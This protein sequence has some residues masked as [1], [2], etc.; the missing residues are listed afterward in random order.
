[1]V[2]AS[3]TFIVRYPELKEFVDNLLADG[4]S[5]AE[6]ERRIQARRPAF[7]RQPSANTISRY[8]LYVAEQ[9]GA[10][11]GPPVRRVMNQVGP[12]AV[13]SVDNAPEED[14]MERAPAG[15]ARAEY[16]TL[17]EILGFF[18]VVLL[19]H[20]VRAFLRMRHL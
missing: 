11:A 4:L 20:L 18:A 12:H 16:L 14:Q 7:R 9:H 10:Q 13:E 17:I 1:M 8:R 6:I 2:L 19:P 5:T 3:P 15:Q